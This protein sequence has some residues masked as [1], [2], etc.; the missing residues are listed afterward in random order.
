MVVARTDGQDWRSDH[1]TWANTGMS[2]RWPAKGGARV[3]Q[4][5]R[6]AWLTRGEEGKIMKEELEVGKECQMIMPSWAEKERMDVH[7]GGSKW[8]CNFN[9]ADMTGDE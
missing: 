9:K 1:H 5:T 2:A 8:E 7:G 3:L 6:L 4:V